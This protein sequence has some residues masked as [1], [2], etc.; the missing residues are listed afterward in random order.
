MRKFIV[1]ALVAG[2]A[3]T[4]ALAQDVAPVAAGTGPR[5]ELLLGYDFPNQGLDNGLNYGVGV[6]FDFQAAGATVGLEGEYMLSDA[7]ESIEDFDVQGDELTAGLG[8]DLYIGGRVGAVVGGSTFVYVKG[9]YTNARLRVKYD[10]GGNG[11]NDFSEGANLDGGRVGAGVE[12]NIPTFGFGSAA[13]LK[14]EYRYSN[15]EAGFEKHQG[16]AGIG[17]RF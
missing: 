13:F 15:Y 12:F 16:V 2:S 9:G 4:P 8:R 11:N 3:T 1:A 5:V 7:E 17:F 10:D 14:A 6:G